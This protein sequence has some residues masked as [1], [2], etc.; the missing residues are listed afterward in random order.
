MI[1]TYLFLVTTCSTNTS[2]QYLVLNSRMYRGS[3]QPAIRVRFWESC[4]THQS[5]LAIPRSLQHL[6][7][8]LLLHASVAVAIPAGSKNSCSPRAMATSL[9]GCYNQPL[10]PST[11]LTFQDTQAHTRDLRP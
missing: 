1:N 4:H 2:A 8:A 9:Q 11:Q 3:L 5:S 10:T 7:R 6:M